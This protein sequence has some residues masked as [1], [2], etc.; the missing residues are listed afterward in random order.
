[1][2]WRDLWTW[3][4]NLSVA[5]IA[6]HG[7]ARGA[8][9]NSSDIY[10][11]SIG[12]VCTIVTATGGKVRTLGT[13]FVTTADGMVATNRHVVEGA[14]DVLVKCGPRAPVTGT[15]VRMGKTVDLALVKTNIRVL[16][17]LSISK[18]D[19]AELVGQPVYVIGS[20]EGLEGTISNGLISGIRRNDGETV[21]QISAP[22]SHGS[23]GGPVILGSGEVIGVATALLR[24]GQNLNFAVP[25]S[26]LA[27]LP[28]MVPESKSL[29]DGSAIKAAVVTPASAFVDF[30]KAFVDRGFWS[31]VD[32]SNVRTLPL[33]LSLESLEQALSIPKWRASRVG[34]ARFDG[35]DVT[36]YALEPDS[37][38]A[39]GDALLLK[40]TRAETRASCL[41]VSA[42][43]DEHL[44]V[45]SVTNEFSFPTSEGG[46]V[47]IFRKQWD[48]PPSR[49]SWNCRSMTPASSDGG[50]GQMTVL[51][52]SIA[53][54][55]KDSPSTWIRCSAS[56]QTTGVYPDRG[57]VVS[58]PKLMPDTVFAIDEF[59]KRLYIEGIGPRGKADFTE[60]R[61]KVVDQSAD[62]VAEV[63]L[64]RRTGAYFETRTV[65]GKPVTAEISGTCSRFD[66][67]RTKF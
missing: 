16:T 48:I 49:I 19:P 18:R 58:A 43:L 42:T 32:W 3:A 21:I 54:S 6:T 39:G 11:R 60:G 33:V 17:P 57:R 44:G 65:P 23:S 9:L 46:E 12:A 62:R 40:R 24:D 41:Q 66:P 52:E 13:G 67:A 10:K 63:V 7:V 22:I 35:G 5:V 8:D 1:M 37:T 26:L 34:G 56:I 47:W 50:F 4:R 61:I 15:V 28:E 64:D 51:G 55:E 29:V 30:G 25:A 27:S 36:A 14:A 59:A 20:P 45:P 2:R 31:S 53:T 38:R